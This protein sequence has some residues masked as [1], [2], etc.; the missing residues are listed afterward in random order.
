[1]VFR[2]EERSDTT[3]TSAAPGRPDVTP[4]R[5][6]SVI[7][8]L[9]HELRGGEAAPPNLDDDL[10]R[11][12]GIDSLAR[13]E[14]MLRLEQAF[15]VR[16]P[17]AAMQAAQ[18]PRDLLRALAAAPLRSSIRPATPAAVGLAPL[19][20]GAA[21]FPY[22]AQTLLDVLQWHADRAGTRRHAALL[23]DGQEPQELDHSALLEHART[24]AVALQRL[25]VAPGNAGL[26]LER[27]HGERR[28]PQRADE[29]ASG[30]A[31]HKFHQQA[32]VMQEAG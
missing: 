3:V 21:D 2:M 14:L 12:L 13:M 11:M 27:S 19:G 17:E 8:T 20:P 32:D 7:Q 5:L 31:V 10:Q 1:M 6:T 28:R 24:I 23:R 9:L 22:Q 26:R 15:D 25:G 29:T 16:M 30:K 18:T 4:A